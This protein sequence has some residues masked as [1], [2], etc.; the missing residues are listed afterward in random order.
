MA[1]LPGRPWSDQAVLVR[2]HAQVELIAEALRAAGIPHRVRGG[3][4]FLD[5][6][7]VRRALRELRASNAPL[8]TA[9]ADLEA[10]I[11]AREAALAPASPLDAGVLPVDDLEAPSLAQP[12]PPAEQ[13]SETPLVGSEGVRRGMF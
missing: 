7:E 6:P 13:S 1:R 5:R 4:S 2:T 3:A 12:A 10:Q 11:H 8:V 9:L